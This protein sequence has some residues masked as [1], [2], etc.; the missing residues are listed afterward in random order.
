MS[1]FVHDRIQF[2]VRYAIVGCLVASLVSITASAHQHIETD[3]ATVK[4]ALSIMAPAYGWQLGWAANSDV[5]TGEIIIRR[6]MTFVNFVYETLRSTDHPYYA[7]VCKKRK[8]LVITDQYP[9]HINKH[10]RLLSAI[11]NFI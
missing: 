8:L 10:C 1:Q 6:D 7:I 11:D 4:E 2:D 9:E 3:T 5:E